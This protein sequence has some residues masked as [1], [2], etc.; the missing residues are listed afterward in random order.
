[1]KILV[2]SPYLPY[3]TI[4]HAGGKLH[5]YNIKTLAKECDMKVVTFARKAELKKSDLDIYNIDNVI[6]LSDDT[7]ITSAKRKIYTFF[8]YFVFFD[9][10]GGFY[11]PLFKNKVLSRL[12]QLKK[13]GYSPDSIYLEWT[14]ALLLLPQIKKIFNYSKFICL[15][16]DISFQSIYRQYK[17]K[18]GFFLNFVWR[19]KYLNLKKYELLCLNK[20][21]NIFVLNT[22]DENLLIDNGIVSSKIAI[23]IPFYDTYYSIQRKNINIKKIIFFG[24]MDRP[25]NY[26]SVI[27]FIENVM[28]QLDNSYQFFIIG[29]NPNKCLSKYKNCNIQITGFVQKIDS[30]FGDCLCMVCPLLFGAG[31]K[32]KVLEAFSAGIPVLAN[33]V[34]IEGIPAVNEKDY[35]QCN[36][37]DEFKNTIIKLSSD[38]RLT[39][40][41][42]V[43]AQNFSKREFDYRKSDSAFKKAI[44]G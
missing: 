34:A 4:G 9:Q 24:A 14:Q 22:K 16:Q 30:Y 29:G 23:R 19:I 41:I 44:L 25:E 31:I 21:D 35:F 1:M 38:F 33:D 39:Y 12:K 11:I 42:G 5:N 40:R 17:F 13:E 28:S 32:I 26:L 10:T 20:C 8:K 2:I 27:W 3:D 7:I 15:E 18:K 37:S 36:T 43:N 6:L